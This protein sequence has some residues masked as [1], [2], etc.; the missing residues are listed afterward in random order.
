MKDLFPSDAKPDQL[1]ITVIRIPFYKDFLYKVD[2]TQF[3]PQEAL[4]WDGPG[5]FKSS[6]RGWETYWTSHYFKSEG[7][8]VI[9]R[10]NLLARQ[11]KFQE[12]IDFIRIVVGNGRYE[13]FRHKA[14]EWTKNGYV[15]SPCLDMFVAN[16]NESFFVKVGDS[17]RLKPKDIR[18]IYLAQEY[19]VVPT[20]VTSMEC[21]LFYDDPL[22]N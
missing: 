2:L 4:G 15:V 17:S 21:G 12:Q 19:L 6:S 5:L 18:F 11:S 22:L 13:S 20:R 7:Y 8:D 9:D 3:I 16:G 14:S 10:F 1:T